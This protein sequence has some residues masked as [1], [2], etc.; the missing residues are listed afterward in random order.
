M[1]SHCHQRNRPGGER[2]K[3]LWLESFQ[4]KQTLTL[5]KYIWNNVN[6]KLGVI[7]IKRLLIFLDL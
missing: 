3:T 4:G 6:N 2:A 7:I 5:M 1:A